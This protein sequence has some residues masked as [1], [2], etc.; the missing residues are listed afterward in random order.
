MSRIILIIAS[1]GFLALSHTQSW[2]DS[3]DRFKTDELALDYLNSQF[4]KFIYSD[5]GISSDI[6]LIYDSLTQKTNDPSYV[7]NAHILRGNIPFVN[8][9]YDEA[10]SQSLEYI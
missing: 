8:T 10:L 1:F 5:P 2:Q 6:L 3:I 7:G 4:S 9:D